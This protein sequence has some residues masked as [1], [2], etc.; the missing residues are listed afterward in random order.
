M[1]LVWLQQEAICLRMFA[2]FL[3]STFP[4]SSLDISSSHG[5]GDYEAKSFLFIPDQ[6]RI[7]YLIL[8]TGY[9]HLFRYLNMII[10]TTTFNYLCFQELCAHWSPPVYP[11]RYSF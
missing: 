8:M 1:L 7:P 2:F 6:L 4:S 5:V 3:G 10:V 9:Q 11:Y